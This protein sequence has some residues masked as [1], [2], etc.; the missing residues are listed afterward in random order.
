MR[1][2]LE[3]GQ[4]GMARSSILPF[5]C[6]YLRRRSLEVSVRFQRGYGS[7]HCFTIK[8]LYGD[9]ISGCDLRDTGQDD[10]GPEIIGYIC[11]FMFLKP[12]E[13]VWGAGGRGTLCMGKVV[14]LEGSGKTLGT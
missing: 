3:E 5:F 13:D 12:G 8:V 4:R 7:E 9:F 6:C 14:R 2:L 11:F 1:L 10:G